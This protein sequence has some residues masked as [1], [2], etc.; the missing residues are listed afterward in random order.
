MPK[1][2]KFCSWMTAKNARV[3]ESQ[4]HVHGWENWLPYLTGFEYSTR[5]KR[6]AQRKAFYVY[7][8]PSLSHSPREVPT[9]GT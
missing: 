6:F 8:K 2:P 1:P 5:P 7:E 3:R 4:D 9:G